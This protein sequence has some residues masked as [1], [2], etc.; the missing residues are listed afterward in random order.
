M[1]YEG[2][3]AYRSGGI[4]TEMYD[5]QIPRGIG[6]WQPPAAS[7]SDYGLRDVLSLLGQVYQGQQTGRQNELE[8]LYRQAQ[9]QHTIETDKEA[10]LR[11]EREF[12]EQQANSAL[13]R[14]ILQAQEGRAAEEAR[15]KPE[16]EAQAYEQDL[17]KTI[18]GKVEFLRPENRD[19]VSLLSPKFAER[20]TQQEAKKKAAGLAEQKRNYEILLKTNPRKAKRSLE[21]LSPEDLAVIAPG[22]AA[23]GA[24]GQPVGEPTKSVI[25]RLT[26]PEGV[27]IPYPDPGA[28]KALLPTA[29]MVTVDPELQSGRGVRPSPPPASNAGFEY[30]PGYPSA[31]PNYMYGIQTPLPGEIQARYDQDPAYMTVEQEILRSIFGNRPPGPAAPPGQ[32]SRLFDVMQRAGIGR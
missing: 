2:N 3:R 9:L 6:Q 8:N 18:A 29:P 5:E 22:E 27:R 31:Q 7:D 25:D 23:G 32:S 19:I 16:R 4:N 11:A 28:L 30:L 15:T 14:Q 26:S 21:G 20:L 13:Q 12:T 24:Q 17:L 10:Q 1:A